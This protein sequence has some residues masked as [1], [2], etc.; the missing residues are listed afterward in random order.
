MEWM[1]GVDDGFM[2]LVLTWMTDI[3]LNPSIDA[4]D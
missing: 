2:G 3:N 1:D 4:V